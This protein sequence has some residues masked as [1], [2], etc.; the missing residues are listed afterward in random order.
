MTENASTAATFIADPTCYEGK[1]ALCIRFL[2]GTVIEGAVAPCPLPNGQGH[3]AK[4]VNPQ[5][6]KPFEFHE[7]PCPEYRSR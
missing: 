4:I 1:C 6:C 7:I 2:N 3:V 5:S